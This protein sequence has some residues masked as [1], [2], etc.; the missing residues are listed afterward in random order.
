M[1]HSII[2]RHRPRGGSD[3]RG[4]Q[5]LAATAALIA[6]AAP[7][8]RADPVE[9]MVPFS[10]RTPALAVPARHTL[11]FSV[12]LDAAGGAPVWSEEKTLFLKTPVVRTFLGDEIPGGLAGVDFGSQLWVEVAR[13]RSGGGYTVLGARTALRP[14]PYALWSERASSI[15]GGVSAAMI[16]DGA[17]STAALAAGAVTLPALGPAA[18]GTSALADG[19]VTTAKLAPGAVGSRVVADGS[20][21]ASRIA[22]GSITAADIPDGTLAWGNFAVPPT[23]YAVDATDEN[24]TF[25]IMGSWPV[26][27]LGKVSA[28]E[29][30]TDGTWHYCRVIQEPGT[31]WVLYARGGTGGNG[32]MHCE[33]VCLP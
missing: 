8:L 29:G 9:P 2:G 11:R 26:C 1:R 14:S 23:T 6:L 20:I 22:S 13:R 17:V 21:T 12:Y 3:V 18:V 30:G 28:T 33:A 19:S 16:Q 5:H 32:S 27:F 31:G 15:A 25:V 10:R 24:Q 4:L 7:G